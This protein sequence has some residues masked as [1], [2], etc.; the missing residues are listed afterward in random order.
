[1]TGI[2]LMKMTQ[3]YK[4]QRSFCTTLCHQDV[5]MAQCYHS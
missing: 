4:K 2:V 5:T 3:L 1:M